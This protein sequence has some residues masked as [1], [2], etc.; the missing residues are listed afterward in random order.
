MT[1]LGERFGVRVE[2]AR[3]Q[4]QDVFV[5]TLTSGT[6]D[7]AGRFHREGEIAAR[8]SHPNIVPLLAHTRTQLIYRFVS[9][10]SLRD[11]LTRGVLDVQQALS[12]T[13]GVLSA[14]AHAHA[15]GITHL[16]LKP[17]NVILEGERVCVTD[18]GLSHDSD[19]PRI[20]GLGARMGTPQYMAPEQF[21][22]VRNDPRSDVYAASVILFECLTG[23]VP[24]PDALAW[25]VG[26]GSEPVTLPPIPALHPALRA[27]LSRD[28]TR[29]PASA[30]AL[31]T[32]LERAEQELGFQ[33]VCPP[34][35]EDRQE[36]RA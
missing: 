20:T 13:R 25:L 16:D 9:G 17:E 2:Q 29:R 5:K 4:G 31:L 22:G 36:E 11:L 8:L 28:L 19:L 18:F 6:P 15:R 10:L 14:V 24:H 1:L 30:L 27:G 26:R 32:L 23:Q 34:L 21:H 35:P 33:P 12:V 3:W 7:T